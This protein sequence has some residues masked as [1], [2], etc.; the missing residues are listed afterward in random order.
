MVYYFLDKKLLFVHEED[1]ENKKDGTISIMPGTTDLL[2]HSVFKKN[3]R[4]KGYNYWDN[5]KKFA[6]ADSSIRDLQTMSPQNDQFGQY[7]NLKEWE[8][9]ISIRF[10]STSKQIK[11][12]IV[13]EWTQKYTLLEGLSKQWCIN[14][15]GSNDKPWSIRDNDV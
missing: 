5:Q 13:P 3:G 1:S 8:I 7:L 10:A 12:Y 9:L 14:K 2:V 4:L 6:A 11:E 15:A